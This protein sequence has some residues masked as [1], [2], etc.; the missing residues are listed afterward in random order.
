METSRLYLIRGI[1]GSGK[2]TI[3]D[4]LASGLHHECK[5]FPAIWVISTDD[6]FTNDKGEYNFESHKLS[7]AHL[8]TQNRV[9]S[10]MESTGEYSVDRFIIL[11]NTFTQNWEMLPYI[12]M[13]GSYGWETCVIRMENNFGNI[14]GV[15]PKVVRN[16][17][18]RFEDFRS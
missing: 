4:V 16:Q 14:H 17:A 3:A 6:F 11:H 2:S 12:K 1:S 10:I 15:P 5:M 9:R 7:L 13:A 18:K 8:E